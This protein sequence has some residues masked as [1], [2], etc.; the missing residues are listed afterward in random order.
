[1]SDFVWPSENLGASKFL[2]SKEGGLDLPFEMSNVGSHKRFL[3]S[4]GKAISL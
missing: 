1:M 4:Y 2:A 3:S